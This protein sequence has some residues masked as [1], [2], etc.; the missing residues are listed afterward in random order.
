MTRDAREMDFRLRL[1]GVPTLPDNDALSI[2]RERRDAVARGG[3]CP[4]AAMR[5]AVLRDERVFHAYAEDLPIER[6]D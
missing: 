5:T 2:A 4:E 6:R 3:D 1:G